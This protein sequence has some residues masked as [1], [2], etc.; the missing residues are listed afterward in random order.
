MLFEFHQVLPDRA[1]R[2]GAGEFAVGLFQEKFGMIFL[3]AGTPAGVID[4]DV[5]EH[6]R[7][8]RVRGIGKF[9]KLVNAGGA[10]VKLDQ[11]RIHGGQIQRGIRAAEPAEARIGG[12]RGMDR[13][14]MED[15]AAERWTMNGS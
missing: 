15:A 13:Q 4:D 10:F 7:A 6:A 8:E 2:A 9:A 1:P 11:G 5:N 14:Q 3:Q 12:G